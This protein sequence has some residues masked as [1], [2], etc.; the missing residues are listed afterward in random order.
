[1]NQLISKIKP[2]EIY[3]LAAQSHVQVSFQTPFYTTFTN[4][5]GT[6]N[7]LE[8]I[9]SNK[10]KNTQNFIKHLLQKCLVIQIL[11]QFLKK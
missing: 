9:K 8:S 6:L 5:I 10:L 2:Q 1:M 4:A 7:I 11:G 3:N